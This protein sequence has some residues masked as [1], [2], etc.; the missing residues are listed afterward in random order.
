M[1][2]NVGSL[3]AHYTTALIPM[4]PQLR[5]EILSSLLTGYLRTSDK[6]S[7]PAESKLI[8]SLCDEV[9]A[10]E[11]RLNTQ[12]LQIEHLQR[13]V[14]APKITKTE[15]FVSAD[16]VNWTAKRQLEMFAE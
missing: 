10:L 13:I 4:A 2:C 6:S 9:Q 11:R 16:G 3:P 15:Q 5:S 8:M 7:N 12:A 1:R 14:K